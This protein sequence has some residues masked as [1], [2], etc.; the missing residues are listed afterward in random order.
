MV[1]VVFDCKIYLV[2]VEFFRAVGTLI[3]R[4]LDWSQLSGGYFR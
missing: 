3:A 2:Y 4:P 1:P